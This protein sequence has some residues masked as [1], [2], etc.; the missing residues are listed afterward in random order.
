MNEILA[1][2]DHHFVINQNS[3]ERKFCYKCGKPLVA[4]IDPPLSPPICSC[5]YEFM[6]IDNFCECCG[7]PK[8]SEPTRP[9][10]LTR[11]VSKIAKFLDRLEDIQ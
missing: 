1:C 11:L 3:S 6:D 5:G 4:G 7:L 9:A 8:P 2:P 10:L